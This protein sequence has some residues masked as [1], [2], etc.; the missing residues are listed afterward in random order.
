MSATP[1]HAAATPVTT[2]PASLPPG[3]RAWLR[4]RRN[5]RGYCSLWIFLAM[6]LAE[7]RRRADL[8]RPAGAGAL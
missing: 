4:F 1:A 2:A 5:R 6:F 3:R 8:Q 7:P